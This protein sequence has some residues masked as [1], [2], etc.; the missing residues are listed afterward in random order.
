VTQAIFS[1]AVT[2]TE[3]GTHTFTATAATGLTGAIVAYAGVSLTQPVL[4]ASGTFA[5]NSS[6][7]L[8]PSLTASVP[9]AMLVGAFVH[10][11]L[12]A[13]TSPAGMTERAHVP[14]GGTAPAARMLTVDQP[15]AASGSTGVRSALIQQPSACTVSQLVALRPGPDTPVNLTPPLVVGTAQE[16]QIVTATTGTWT[17]SPTSYSYQWQRSADGQTWAGISGATAPSLTVRTVDVGMAIR[18]VVVATNASGSRSANS[19]PTQPVLP[20]PPVNLT[21]PEVSGTPMENETLAATTGSWSGAPTGHLYAWE[22]CDL[23]GG[24]CVAIAGAGGSSYTLAGA[25]VGSRVRVVVTA[26][27]AGGSASTASPAGAAVEVAAPPANLTPPSIAGTA[28]ANE[29]LTADPGAWSGWPTALAFRWQQSADGGQTFTDIADASGS[30]YTP[31]VAEIGLHIRVAVTA[32]NASGEGTAVSEATGPVLLPGPV[33]TT[34][35]VLS[36]LALEGEVLHA[37]TGEWLGDPTTFAF[38]WRR[39]APDGTG[40]VAIGSATSA[41]YTVQGDDVSSV[42]R[43]AVTATNAFGSTT[44]VSEASSVVLPLPPVGVVSPGIAGI[45]EAGQTLSA[46]VGEWQSSGVLSY[47]YQWQASTDGGSTWSDIAGAVG[48]TY[49]LTAGDVG[50]TIRVSVTATNAGG[51]AAAESAP[52]GT[53]TSVGAPV[54]VFHPTMTGVLQPGG[55]LTARPGTWSGSPSFAYQWQ[56]SSDGGST[57]TNVPGAVGQTLTLFAADIG[58]AVR[59]VVTAVNSF[60]TATA[61]SAGFDVYPTGNLVV[62]VNRP[63]GCNAAVDVDLVKVTFDDG[64]NTD[65]IRLDGCRGRIGRVEVDTNGADGI[66]VRNGSTVAQDLVVEGGYIR[67]TDHPAGAHQDGIQVMGGYRITFRALVVWCSNPNG[68]IGD[69]VNSQ[70]MIA[71]AGAGTATPTDVVV[72]RSALGP[73]TANGFFVQTS[74]RSGIRDSVVCPDLTTTGGSIFFGPEAV[75]GVDTGNEE[76][77]ASDPRCTSF[78]AALA[79][80][81]TPPAPQSP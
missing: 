57:W 13:I 72:E 19:A 2:A 69:G 11:G 42:L 18:V 58:A 59:L 37:T 80:V 67:C 28:Q 47:A 8:A 68:Q 3:P 49:T 66:K 4:A 62:F 33:S 73:G 20:A 25:D 46:S 22:R 60:G 71:L 65:A 78:E 64:S 41:D 76:L 50:S 12:G 36:G 81:E 6:V 1:R 15:L 30:T 61:A 27:N 14:T 9:N 53:V 7:L 51:S 74:I 70:I 39:C 5:R 45:P 10:T 56:R 77:P 26:S 35:P 75:D 24:N 40:C 55:R 31:G 43:V 54:N 32:T 34:P 52:T 44:A 29:T 63:W 79:W 21:P 48:Q 38:E 17:G 23:A 16:G